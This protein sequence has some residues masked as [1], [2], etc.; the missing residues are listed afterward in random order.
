MKTYN[1]ICMSFDGSFVNDSTHTTI[2]S[3]ENMSAEMGSK[4]YFYP[5]HFIV[6]GS[7]IKETG[8][9]LINIETHKPYLEILFKGKRLKTVVKEFKKAN[10]FCLE[11]DIQADC[12]EFEEILIHQIL[13]Q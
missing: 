12:Y 9:G 7:T 3:A 4:W 8:A 5:F 10:K 11:N 1:L 13:N 6:S 2:D